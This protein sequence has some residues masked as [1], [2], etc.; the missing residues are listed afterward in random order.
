MQITDVKVKLVPDEGRRDRLRAFCSV[1]FDDVFVVHDLK[2]IDGPHGLFVAMPSRQVARRC[3]G[4]GSKQPVRA[5]YCSDCGERSPSAPR[6]GGDRTH[7]FIDVAH[8]INAGFRESIHEAIL[9]AYHRVRE[10]ADEAPRQ[11]AEESGGPRPAAGGPYLRTGETTE[12][13]LIDPGPL[14]LAPGRFP[15][16][17]RGRDRR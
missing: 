11:A 13:R 17:T 15:G 7:D 16:T 6:R 14:P 10:D 3:A 4:C 9:E 12:F 2:L 5:R 1:T 8:P